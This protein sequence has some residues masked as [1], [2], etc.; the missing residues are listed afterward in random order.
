MVA[1]PVISQRWRASLVAEP[2]PVGQVVTFRPIDL[3]APLPSMPGV[4]VGN[5]ALDAA[6]VLAHCCFVDE[7]IDAVWS[8]LGPRL[9]ESLA[10]AGLTALLVAPFVPT[11]AGTDTYLDQLW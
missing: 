1:R 7:P 4:A 2:S 8:V 3:P 10:A 11:V 5:D 9:E 6:A